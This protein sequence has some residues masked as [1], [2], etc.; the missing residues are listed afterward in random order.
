MARLREQD[1]AR[2][3]ASGHGRDFLESL[4]RG[5]KVVAAFTRERSRMTLSEVAHA[6]DLPRPTA[7]RVLHTLAC[8]GFV[9]AEGPLFRLTPRI[10]TLAS[11]YLGSNTI[12]KIAQP[13][14]E[15]ISA[16]T[17]E[18]CFVAVMDGLD[19]AIIAHAGP[20]SPVVIGA[21][22]G[23]RLPAFCTAAGRAMLSQ[24][25][26]DALGEWLQAVT[27]TALTRYTITDKAALR[28]QTLSTRGQ[29]YARTDQETLLGFRAIAFPLRRF[30]GVCVAALNLAV[31]IVESSIPG[32]EEQFIALL[33][34][35]A[36]ALQNQLI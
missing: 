32:H 18:V 22:I 35:E 20:L 9:E 12:S 17:G 36:A 34:E 30:D 19:I 26:D 28:E 24:L 33:R 7:R 14:C 21:G 10:L 5:L 11:A 27:P 31:R 4:A 3:V 6:A 15:R 2:R 29:G 1:A 8:L 16:L 13:V 25:P 23:Q